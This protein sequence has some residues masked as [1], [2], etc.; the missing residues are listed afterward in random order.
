VARNRILKTQ[1]DWASRGTNTHEKEVIIVLKKVGLAVA[2][3]AALLAWGIV[4]TSTSVADDAGDATCRYQGEVYPAGEL[5][6]WHDGYWYRC[7]GK[8]GQWRNQRQ[9]CRIM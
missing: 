2:I 6:C 7:D 4:G 1:V 3:S 5:V 8:T 9:K